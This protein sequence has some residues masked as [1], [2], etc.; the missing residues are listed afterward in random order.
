M[1][2]SSRKLVSMPIM[3]QSDRYGMETAPWVTWGD[4]ADSIGPIRNGNIDP[5]APDVLC[6]IQMDRYGMETRWRARR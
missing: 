4:V 3:I 6:P 5:L 2:T 1:E